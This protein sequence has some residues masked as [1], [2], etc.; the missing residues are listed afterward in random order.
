MS[1]NIYKSSFVRFSPENTKIINSDELVQKRM[2]MYSEVLRE[3]EESAPASEGDFEG[4]PDDAALDA[5][6]GDPESEEGGFSEG[7]DPYVKNLPSQEDYQQACD[8]MIAKAT[9][10][11]SSILAEANEDAANIREK[12][13]DNGFKEGYDKGMS[14]ALSEYEAKAAALDAEKERLAQEY[15]DALDSVESRMVDVI[16]SVYRKV[17][18]EGF[19]HKKDVMVAL[20]SRALS[21][22]ETDDKI[23]IHVSTEDYDSVVDAK[24]EIFG[25][26]SFPS[27]PEIRARD[28]L[29]TG[30]AKVETSYGIMDVSIETELKEL[31]KA[32][33][34]LSHS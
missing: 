18:S 25:R 9:A 11:A 8:D 20:I 4:G 34:L 30:Q 7:I 6:T 5:L 31:E 29:T 12:A 33:I 3:K 16:T 27:E 22:V 10:Q 21:N 28:S 15:Q 14:Q 2:E 32:L 1:K 24:D 17:F 23:I 13:A 26:T 19:Y